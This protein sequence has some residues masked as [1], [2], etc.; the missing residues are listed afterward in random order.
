MIELND[1]LEAYGAWL[2]ACAREEER[3][4][5]GGDVESLSAGEDLV[6]KFKPLSTIEGLLHALRIRFITQ[7]RMRWSELRAGGLC[8]ALLSAEERE[9]HSLGP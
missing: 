5:L 9:R 3:S 6:V 8:S 1:R 4:A 2:G 7:Y